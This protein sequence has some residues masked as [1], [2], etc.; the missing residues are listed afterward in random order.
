MDTLFTINPGESFVITEG[1]EI[2]TANDFKAS[3]VRS[4]VDAPLMI[5]TNSTVCAGLK[6]CRPANR[7]LCFNPEA[8]K[9]IGNEDVLLTRIQSFA[10]SFSSSLTIFCFTSSRSITAS[11][12]SSTCSC[13]KSPTACIRFKASSLLFACKPALSNACFKIFPNVSNGRS[14]SAQVGYHKAL[15]N[16]QPEHKLEQFLAP[17]CR[18]LQ[19]RYFL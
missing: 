3:I 13:L 12:A 2:L 7:S 14:A 6:K 11:I 16:S 5:S 8:I 9:V 19:W 17:S 10:F 15:P 18:L 4:L 1:F